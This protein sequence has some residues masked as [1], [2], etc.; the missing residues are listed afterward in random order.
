MGPIQ[1]FSIWL[2]PAEAEAPRLQGWIDR[3]AG[4]LGTV[5][6]SPHVTLLGGLD[7]DADPDTAQRAL[8][9]LADQSP[10]SL[11]LARLDDEAT[12]F[13][14]VTLRA[15]PTGR[16]LAIRAAIEN[17]L[18]TAGGPFLPHLSL[19]YGDLDAA[20]KR[21]HGE[22]LGIPLPIEAV[23]DGIELWRTD[24]SDVP[25]WRRLAR[26]PLHGC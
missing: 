6:F 18:A 23:F 16:L 19:L 2:V 15:E 21:A 20:T 13:R 17:A 7:A 8:A 26:I 12:H 11:S 24:E 1:R 25:G 9:W 5:A 3:L 4:E 22:A 14:A 10:L